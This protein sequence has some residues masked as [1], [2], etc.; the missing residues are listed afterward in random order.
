M[1]I[2]KLANVI[3]S[4]AKN[5]SQALTHGILRRL[6]PQNDTQDRRFRMDISYLTSNN[7]SNHLLLSMVIQFSVACQKIIEALPL[8]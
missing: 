8:L 1:S 5:L 7:L 4:V 2:L 3:L 6:V